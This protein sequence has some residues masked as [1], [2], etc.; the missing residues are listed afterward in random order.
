VP[1]PDKELVT[2]DDY[3][4]RYAQY[5]EDPDL[6]A[7]HRRHPFIP[8]WDDHEFANDAWHGGADNHQ[9]EDGDWAARRAAAMQAWREWMPVRDSM[10]PDFRLYRQFAF[11]DLLDLFMLDTRI[12]GRDQQVSPRDVAA[13]ED[14]SRQLLGPQQEEWLFAGL[15][16]STAAGKP[17][18]IL[19][20]QVMF[21]P[22]VPA[23]A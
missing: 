21:S 8:I 2:L 18:Q 16:D 6:Q 1:F 17:W 12:V 20:Q 5:R 19:G 23:G 10:G 15:R 3:R 4:A 11:G 7:V 13:I 22:Q 14:P 9:K